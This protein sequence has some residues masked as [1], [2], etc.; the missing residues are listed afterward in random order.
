MYI[1]IGMKEIIHLY[2]DESY[3]NWYKDYFLNVN[4]IEVIINMY[5]Y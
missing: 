3:L 2:I 4:R 5:Q 1:P